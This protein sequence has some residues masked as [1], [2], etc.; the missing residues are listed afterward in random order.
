MDKRRAR[1]LLRIYRDEL[2]DKVMPFWLKYGVDR[3]H[4]GY[5]GGVERD[6]EVYDRD[7]YGLFQGRVAFMFSHLCNLWEKRQEWLEAAKQGVD[8]IKKH[9]FDV[10]GGMYFRLTEDG[11]PLHRSRAI[12][13]ESFAV[14][15]LAEYAKAAGDEEAAAL[16]KD[17]YW[18]LVDRVRNSGT[19]QDNSYPENRPVV[20]H[21][22]PM[23]M[24]NTTQMIRAALPDGD[25]QQVAR[26]NLDKILKLHYKPERGM[27]L[28][29]VGPAGEELDTP[30]GRCLNPGHMIES[31]WFVMREGEHLA[32]QKVIEAGMS[33]ARHAMRLGWDDK[34]GG[35]FSFLDAEGKTPQQP[36]WDMKLWWPHTEALYALLLATHHSR[37]AGFMELFDKVHEWTFKYFPDREYG[38]WYGYLHRDGSVANDLKA[39]TLKGCFHVPRALLYCVKLLE[40]IL[41][42]S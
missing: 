18:R 19:A 14:M 21:G 41:K 4:G 27:V 1:E 20:T 30:E 36:E 9:A 7:K 12:F 10:D 37:E 15:A 35:L 38:E 39:S 6:G 13:G 29:T 34:H 31:A 22:V 24:L 42:N 11:R 5:Y 23:I 2:L 28:E 8:F 33:I 25:Y 26:E 3:K 16:A 17:V 32:D 40:R